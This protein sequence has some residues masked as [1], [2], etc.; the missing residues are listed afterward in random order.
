MPNTRWIV[1]RRPE[2]PA[3]GNSKEV[4]ERLF[5]GAT[6]ASA[7]IQGHGISET[8]GSRMIAPAIYHCVSRV[9]DRRFVFGTREKDR[10]VEMMRRAELFSGV[11]VLAHCVM[12]NHFHILVEIPPAPAG[13]LGDTDLLNRLA[14]L[15]DEATVDAVANELER[16]R[17]AVAEGR[18]DEQRIEEIHARY[19]YR[20]HDLS[21]FMKTLIQRFTQWFNRK[22]NRTGNLWE[23]V[24]RSSV[25]EAGPAARLVAAYIDLNPL[26]A[27]IVEDPADYPWSSYGEAAAKTAPRRKPTP[28][29]ARARGGLVRAFFAHLG[30]APDATRWNECLKIYQPWIAQAMARMQAVRAGSRAD[31][32]LLES[33]GA[34][35]TQRIRHFTDGAVIGSRSYIDGLFVRERA[36]FGPRRTTGARPIRGSGAMVASKEGVC[37]L[38]DL[39][40]NISA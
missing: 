10:F 27:G 17:I 28:A 1:H 7:V 34:A 13:G 36:R 5:D 26:R 2:R 31:H 12:S 8:E 11:R 35:L 22:N 37:S 18:A 15:Y 4:G 9:V 29:V 33:P 14:A 3:K 21:E 23:D 6:T 25:V 38:R 40:K 20:M 30:A 39:Q 24:F 16:G 19:H 32:R